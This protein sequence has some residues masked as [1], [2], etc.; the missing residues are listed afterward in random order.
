MW[1]DS[2]YVDPFKVSINVSTLMTTKPQVNQTQVQLT[3]ISSSIKSTEPTKSRSEPAPPAEGAKVSSHTK[4]ESDTKDMS[5][6]GN[7]NPVTITYVLF[8][9]ALDAHIY[10]PKGTIVTHPDVNEPEMVVIEIVKTIEEVQE[11]M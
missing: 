4:A 10:I 11:T 2:Y 1:A 3:P 8:N 7:K 6:L 5:T 9:L